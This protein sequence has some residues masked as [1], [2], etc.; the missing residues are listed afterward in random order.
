MS[1]IAIDLGKF[2]SMV[3]FYDSD[4]QEHSFWNAATQREYLRTILTKNPCDLVVMEACSA[5]PGAPGGE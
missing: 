3:C 5:S 1:I 4:T 2:N